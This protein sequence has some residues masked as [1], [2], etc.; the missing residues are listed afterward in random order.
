MIRI[1]FRIPH[2][3]FNLGGIES[4]LAALRA[5]WMETLSRP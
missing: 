3:V 5:V 2:P 4:Q 1:E